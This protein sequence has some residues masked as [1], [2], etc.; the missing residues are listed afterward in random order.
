M[1]F[2]VAASIVTLESSVS[3]ECCVED[4]AMVTGKCRM[5]TYSLIYTV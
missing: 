1:F 5:H 2:L 3:G 4:S